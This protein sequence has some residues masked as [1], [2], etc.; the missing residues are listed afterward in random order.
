MH[1]TN[2]VIL[3][4]TSLI[5]ISGIGAGK[6]PTAI[7]SGQCKPENDGPSAPGCVKRTCASNVNNAQACSHPNT[8][9]KLCLTGTMPWTCTFAHYPVIYGLVPNGLGAQ[10]CIG[11]D[12]VWTNNACFTIVPVGCDT[13]F[14]QP[15]C[16]C[17]AGQSCDHVASGN[18]QYDVQG[19]Y[20]SDDC[21]E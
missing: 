6:C 4:V 5:A 20:D 11:P 2:R 12:K 13:R 18:C 7:N 14:P 8:S 19:V 21:K 3:I 15:G 16:G 17:P 10:F 9:T 1:I